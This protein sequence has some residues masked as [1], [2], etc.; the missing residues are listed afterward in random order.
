MCS[1]TSDWTKLL[2]LVTFFIASETIFFVANYDK[3]Y[4]KNSINL[5]FQLICLFILSLA[6]PEYDNF[7]GLDVIVSYVLLILFS[8]IYIGISY[9]RL[10]VYAAGKIAFTIINILYSLMLASLIPF[11][12][13]PVYLIAFSLLSLIAIEWKFNSDKSTSINFI[14]CFHMLALIIYMYQLYYVDI[15]GFVMTYISFGL[16]IIPFAL[17]GYSTKEKIYQTFSMIYLLLFVVGFSMDNTAY[18]IVGLGLFALLCY[19]LKEKNQYCTKV[20]TYIYFMFMIFITRYVSLLFDTIDIDSTIREFIIFALVCIVHIAAVKT[21]FAR[22]WDDGTYENFFTK[23]T[24]IVNAILMLFA[25]S[26]IDA[27][28]EYPILHFITILL[29]LMLFSVN[30]KNLLQKEHIGWGIYVG[31]K[32]TIYMIA[33]LDSFATPDFGISIGCLLFAIGSI[34]CGFMLCHKSLRVYGLVLS[35]LSVAKLV[36]LDINYENTLGHAFSFFI[37][38]ILCFVIS[39][40]YNMLD[41]KITK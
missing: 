25:L 34:V 22:N 30:S 3:D 38:G 36:M 19:L 39:T 9:L 20:K 7:S 41:K 37:C 8:L 16:L 18:F 32:F 33:I 31:I 17:Y 35:L 26:G 28:A 12:G 10:Q 1:S 2:F 5:G 11:S 14:Q 6:L 27:M 23:A 4:I 40:I 15:I 24:N 21:P 29:A 13:K